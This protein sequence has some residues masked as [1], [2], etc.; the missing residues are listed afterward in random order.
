MTGHGARFSAVIRQGQTPGI[1]AMQR[2]FQ[3]S[4]LSPLLIIATDLLLPHEERGDLLAALLDEP[5]HAATSLLLLGAL[6][7]QAS[8]AAQI[9]TLAGGNGMDVDHVPQVL[10]WHGLIPAGNARPCTHSLATLLASLVAASALTGR[11]R[12][13]A[14]IV[15]FGIL[16]HFIRDLATG[17]MPLYWPLN[18]RRVRI[19]YG[20]YAALLGLASLVQ[21]SAWLTRRMHGSAT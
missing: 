19:P 7:P 1:E 11:A 13:L 20:V 5:A 9:A 4:A 12:S 18:N 16:T 14:A 15:S 3:W 2:L 6:R 17:G 21:T 10:G 8:V